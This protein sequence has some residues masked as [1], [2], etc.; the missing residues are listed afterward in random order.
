MYTEK[1]TDGMHYYAYVLVYVNDILVV[2]HNPE[3]TM[4]V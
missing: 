4:K 3:A 2:S 1:K